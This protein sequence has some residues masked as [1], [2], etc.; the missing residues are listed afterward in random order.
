MKNYFLFLSLIFL[1]C[2]NEPADPYHYDAANFI[3]LKKDPCF[4]FCPVYTV[5]I[6]GKGE[7]VF[8]GQKN[9]SKE[10]TWY[11][12]LPPDETNNMFKTFEDT[13]FWELKDE[14]TAQVTDLPTTWISLVLGE[15]SKTIK[16]YYG[17]PDELKA[18]ELMI[19][20]IAETDE[21]WKRELSDGE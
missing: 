1:A 17:A 4:G 13:G 9:I 10:G 19:E 5:K 15:K 2:A 12:T 16:D 6:N 20:K 11:R 21:N 18:L 3:E 8:N 14:Y 7:V